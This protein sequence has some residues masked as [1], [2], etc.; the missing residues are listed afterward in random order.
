MNPQTSTSHPPYE[1]L[2]LYIDGY[3]VTKFVSQA[4]AVP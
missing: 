3:L 4:S 1:A 2:A